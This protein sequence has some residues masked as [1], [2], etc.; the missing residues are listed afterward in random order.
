M[1]GNIVAGICHRYP[2]ALA[3]TAG[4]DSRTILA[5]SRASVGKLR[6][7]TVSHHAQ[8]TDPADIMSDPDVAGARRLALSLDLHHE[9][10]YTEP[11][12]PTGIW[13]TLIEHTATP[14]RISD[15]WLAA[16][17]QFDPPLQVSING[18]CSEAIRG[19]YYPI[20]SRLAAA[21]GDLAHLYT[22][23]PG[24][25]FAR[26]SLEP[27]FKDAVQLCRDTNYNLL[28][29]FHWELKLGRL[30]SQM[31]LEE[32]LVMEAVHP[33]NCREIIAAGLAVDWNSRSMP[34]G[35]LLHKRIIELMWPE[36]LADAPK[37]KTKMSMIRQNLRAIK[38]WHALRNL[39]RRPN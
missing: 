15:K 37:M 18:A 33:F 2:A 24:N 22:T 8:R 20:T 28:D 21:G 11:T 32:D 1:L 9:V 16:L 6:L 10:A 31:I 14:H 35:S 23:G 4:L 29:L 34:A 25:D 39:A 13:S 17:D 5:A 38:G 3:L 26:R 30:S 7:Y 27:W 12:A 36:C 19:K